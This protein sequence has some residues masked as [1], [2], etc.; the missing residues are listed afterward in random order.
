MLLTACAISGIQP[1]SIRN[2]FKLNLTYLTI[3]SC[4]YLFQKRS[5]LQNILKNIIL[6]NLKYIY[7]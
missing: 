4:Y 3:N 5:F 1:N 7:I 2:N 6:L